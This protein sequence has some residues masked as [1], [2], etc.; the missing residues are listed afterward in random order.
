MTTS[1]LRSPIYPNSV[2]GSTWGSLKHAH[3][4]DGHAVG[5]L[6]LSKEEDRLE[7]E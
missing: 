6:D 4:T 2:S 7:H 5:L 3:D 1:H